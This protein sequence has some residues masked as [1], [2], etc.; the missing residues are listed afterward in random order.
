MSVK[1]PLIYVRHMRDCCASIRDYL[2]GAGPNW[3]SSPFVT[4]AVCRNIA[5][6]GEAARKVD[7]VNPRRTQ[8]LSGC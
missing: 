5:I 1:D 6:I 8:P 2:A 4:D 7:P 3:P